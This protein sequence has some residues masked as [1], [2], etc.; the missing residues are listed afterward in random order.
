MDEFKIERFQTE[1]PGEALPLAPADS[2]TVQSMRALLSRRLGLPDG[3]PGLSLVQSILSKS[4]PLA[5]VSA[6]SPEFSLMEV[7]SRQAGIDLEG[8]VFLNWYRFD[9]LDRMRAK[10]I[11]RLLHDIW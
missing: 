2:R 8:E 5:G 1:H 7:L 9:Q 6:L 4:T 3:S 11:S 10:D